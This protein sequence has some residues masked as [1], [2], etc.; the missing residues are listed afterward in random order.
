MR[1]QPPKTKKKIFNREEFKDYFLNH[2]LIIGGLGL[3]IELKNFFPDEN[4]HVHLKLD[5]ERDL[6]QMF[7]YVYEH[8]VSELIEE[9]IKK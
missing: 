6:I 4:G 3:K 5:N 9:L 1:I 8:M 2:V 7:P